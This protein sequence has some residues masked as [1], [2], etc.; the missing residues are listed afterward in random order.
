ML[1]KVES[2]GIN[3]IDTYQRSG[4]Y[5]IP[6][7]STLGL[8]AAGTVVETGANVT[9]LSA[10]DRVA[11]TNVAGAYAEFAAVPADWRSRMSTCPCIGEGVQRTMLVKVKQT[12]A[13]IS[14]TGLLLIQMVKMLGLYQIPP[15]QKPNSGLEA[16]GTVVEADTNVTGLNIGDSVGAATT[17]VAGA[18]VTWSFTATPCRH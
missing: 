3:F 2:A 10:G 17:N 12:A 16:A 11:Y 4:L 5:Q 18:Y 7:P 13:S 9:G 8:E 15:N 1:V 14:S 6:L